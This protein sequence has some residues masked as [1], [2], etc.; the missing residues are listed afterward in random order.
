MCAMCMSCGWKCCSQQS[1][2]YSCRY[3]VY[4]CCDLCIV[5]TL[6]WL[7]LFQRTKLML[8]D[9]HIILIFFTFGWQLG[10]N[11]HL[12]FQ[13]AVEDSSRL[14]ITMLFFF[15][16]I[17]FDTRL[18]GSGCS[19]RCLL[20]EITSS[21]GSSWIKGLL[22]CF[23]CLHGVQI[24][25]LTYMYYPLCVSALT[26]KNEG[27]DETLKDEMA[28]QYKAIQYQQLL[29]LPFQPA[30]SDAQL[31]KKSSTRSFKKFFGK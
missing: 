12:R 9:F 31:K 21:P 24:L 15:F 26:V 14:I 4:D 19:S 25:L 18:S 28:Q 30:T 13:K 10:C 6:Q 1:V 29:Q 17:V 23:V 20:C 16:C 11:Q 2:L 7:T 8:L 5:I 27:E 3:R 22:V